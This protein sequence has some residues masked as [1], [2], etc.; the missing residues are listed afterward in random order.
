MKKKTKESIDFLEKLHKYITTNPTFRKDTRKKKETEIQ[1]EIRPLIIGFLKKYFKEKGFK[2]HEKKAHKSFYWEGQEGTYGKKRKTTFGARNYPDFIIEDPY[3]IAIEYK[4]ND[5]GAIVKHGI[6]QSIVHT[7][8]GDFDF[9]YYLFHDQNKD[10]KIV[11][12]LKGVIE[13][14]IIKL[15]WDEFNIFL[16]II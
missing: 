5:N 13:K 4:Q 16:R 15:I 9:V 1:T 3:L 12:S 8:S 10:K 11:N 2:D 7:L 14:N 6:G